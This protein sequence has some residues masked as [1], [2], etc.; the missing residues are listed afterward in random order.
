M[1][2]RFF[3]DGIGGFRLALIRELGL[4]I[5]FVDSPSCLARPTGK[6]VVKELAR[7]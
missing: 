4:V 3:E 7:A 5:V 2:A 1:G 6:N